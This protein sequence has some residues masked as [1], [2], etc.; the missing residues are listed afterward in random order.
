MYDNLGEEI[1]EATLVEKILRS[2]SSKFESKLFAI[3]EKHDLQTITVNQLHGILTTFEMRE[4]T[5]KA[6]EKGKE[7]EEHNELGYIL[8]E[9]Y[10]VNFF[11]KPQWGSGRFKGK[12]PLK[13]FSSGRVNHYVA[14]CLHKDKYEKGKEY[15]KGNRK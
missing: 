3:K 6:L 13:F 14:K 10:E 11:K 1:K 9:E 5:F 12:L 8:E 7:K 4:A 2:L 15:E